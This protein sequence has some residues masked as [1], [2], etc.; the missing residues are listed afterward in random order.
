[1]LV[2]H[3]SLRIAQAIKDYDEDLDLVCLDP[4]LPGISINSAPFMVVCRMPDGTYQKVFDAWQ[5]D[6]RILERLW[7]AD[8]QRF[9]TLDS[10]ERINGKVKM[11]K[12]HRYLEKKESAHEL[13]LAIL[14][15]KQSSYRYT[16]EHG[17][18]VRINE[19]GKPSELNKNR[20]SF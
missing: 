10:I 16:N 18:L 6:D 20:K 1:M 11:D 15:S 5:L 12:Y 7:A 19:T 8:N 9:D 13:A 17:D 3:D 2:E 14:K 4:D